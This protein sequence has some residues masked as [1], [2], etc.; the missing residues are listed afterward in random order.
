MR[1]KYK[2]IVLKI[3]KRERLQKYAVVE[4]ALE[5]AYPEEFSTAKN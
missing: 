4:K 3:A 1:P 2:E 5:M